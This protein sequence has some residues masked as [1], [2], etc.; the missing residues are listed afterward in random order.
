MSKIGIF[1]LI[2]IV[3]LVGIGLWYNQQHSGQPVLYQNTAN[4]GQTN[5]AQANTSIDQDVSNVDAELSAVAAGSAS[6]DAGL[7]DQPVQ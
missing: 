7:N 6:A 2:I 1:I 4:S 5:R 3:V